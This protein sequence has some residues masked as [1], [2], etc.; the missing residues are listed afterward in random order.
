MSA[1]SLAKFC[2]CPHFAVQLPAAMGTWKYI[3]SVMEHL[4]LDTPIYKYVSAC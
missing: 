1:E 2:Y 3:T 4:T